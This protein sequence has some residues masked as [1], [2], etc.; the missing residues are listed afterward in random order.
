MRPIE[1]YGDI[2]Y[3]VNSYALYVITKEDTVC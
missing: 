1:R 2:L 3:D